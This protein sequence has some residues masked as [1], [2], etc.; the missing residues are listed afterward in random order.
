M[1]RE[2]GWQDW[3]SNSKNKELYSK[4]MKEGLRQFNLEKIRRDNLT[5]SAVF[6]LKGM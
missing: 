1:M 3:I 5:K 6:N 2:Y 4:D